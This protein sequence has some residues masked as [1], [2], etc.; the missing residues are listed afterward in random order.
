MEGEGLLQQMTVHGETQ[1]DRNSSSD[2]SVHMNPQE[3]ALK[4]QRY[5]K[6]KWIESIRNL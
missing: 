2:F 3:Q 6:K 4:K 5:G 1:P